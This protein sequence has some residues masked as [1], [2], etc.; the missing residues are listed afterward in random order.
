MR[1]FKT[2]VAGAVLGLAAVSCA[3]ASGVTVVCGNSSLGIR[4]T[5]VDPALAGSCWA[6]LTNLGDPDLEAL[7]NSTYGTTDAGIIDRDTSNSNGGSLSITG[8]GTQSG[9]WSFLDSLWDQYDRLF[10]YFHFGDAQD[11]PSTTSTTDPDVFMVELVSP[12]SAGT[13]S[14]NGRTGLSN[15]A[16]IGTGG[17]QV[18]EP[19]SL[20]LVGLGLVAVA[21]TRRRRRV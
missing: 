3:Q 11:N 12:D 17:H 13:W 15:I 2:L 9:T 16:L 21:M 7:V 8:V 14:F 4:T 20:A 19:G 10:L 5:T 18:P 6:G 1:M